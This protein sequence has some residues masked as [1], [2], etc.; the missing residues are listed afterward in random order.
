M[1]PACHGKLDIRATVAACSECFAEFP[2]IN[3]VPILLTDALSNQQEHQKTYYDAEYG[4]YAEYTPANWRV[5]FNRRIFAALGLP[6]SGGPFLDVG[7]GGSGATVI[8]AA[9]AGVTGAGCDLSVDGVSTARRF[10]EAEGVSERLT[11]AVCAAEQLPFADGSF[12]CASMVAVL[13]HLDDDRVAAAEL[14]RVVRPGGRVWVTV[15]NAYRHIP[16]PLWPWYAFHDRRV[17]HKRHY[18]NGALA[19]MMGAAGFELVAVVY[20]GHPVKVTQFALD[21]VLRGSSRD[22][23]WWDLERRDH[24]H[25]DRARGALQL[26]GVFERP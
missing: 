25:S 11:F 9:R 22:R 4:A 18:D 26:N 20:S 19:G 2:V 6:E 15:P 21:H 23:V 1:C 5:S 16:M 13:E 24:V 12:G 3:G 10:A 8:E 7:V 17:G 14:A